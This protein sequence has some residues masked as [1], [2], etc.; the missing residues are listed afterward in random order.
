MV[1]TKWWI[2]FIKRKEVAI[3]EL[4]NVFVNTWIRCEDLVWGLGSKTYD[5]LFVSA[6]IPTCDSRKR[7]TF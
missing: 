3:S 2:N 1:K 6:D 7:K 4:S 5:L